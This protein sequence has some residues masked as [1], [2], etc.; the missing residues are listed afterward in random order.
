MVANL[1]EATAAAAAAA[2]AA[3]HA[4]IIL[5]IILHACETPFV[6]V[7][8]CVCVCGGGGVSAQVFLKEHNLEKEMRA[9]YNRSVE[10]GVGI[11]P[12][13]TQKTAGGS[14]APASPAPS[15]KAA[16]AN[17]TAEKRK[18][19]KP[20]KVSTCTVHST[21]TLLRTQSLAR[22]HVAQCFVIRT[23]VWL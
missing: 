21:I 18:A 23:C 19:D 12:G 6:C 9:I 10:A 15:T 22:R 1:R 14:A 2:A 4:G 20:A 13:K 8:V 3:C 16:Q 7:C 5:V 11:N 17:G